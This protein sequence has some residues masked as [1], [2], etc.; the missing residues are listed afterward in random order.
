MSK[1]ES[2]AD[3]ASAAAWL[4]LSGI[5]VSYGRQPAVRGFS[6]DVA[7]G[8][9]V[10][11]AGSNGAGKT[12]LLT[13]VAGLAQ[14]GQRL[15]GVVRLNGA[16]LRF[17]DVAG[18]IAAGIRLVPERDKVFRLL[19]VGE[20]LMVGGRLARRSGI[21][22]DDV[23]DWFPRLHERRDTLAGNLSGGEQQMLAI[24]LCLLAGPKLLLLDEPTLGLAAPV[25]EDV[26]ARLGRLRRELYLTILV[27]ESD[28][29]WLPHLADRAVAIDRGRL[30]ASFPRLD[31]ASLDAVHDVLLGLVPPAGGALQEAGIA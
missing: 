21:G 12:S 1:A 31:A 3:G 18:H 6:L 14:R 19:T 16:R 9:S 17:A 10:A 4:S 15:E 22:L 20:N 28:S 11:L 26:C 30:V 2:H 7:R 13:T 27:A 24:A 25:I 5:G 29:Q 23:F 8:E